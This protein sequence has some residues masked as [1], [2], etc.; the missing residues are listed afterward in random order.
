MSP[1]FIIVLILMPAWAYL[2]CTAIAAARF[3]RCSLPSAREQ[4]PVSLLKPLHGTEPGLYEN[5]RSFVEQDYPTVQ[6]VLG[7]NDEKD[8]ALP[9]AKALIRD[10]PAA[11]ITFVVEA[12][13]RGSNL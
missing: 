12:P 1:V 6:I 4:P 9:V 10:M 2:V 8:A 3:A 11:D 13:V 5:L 7:V